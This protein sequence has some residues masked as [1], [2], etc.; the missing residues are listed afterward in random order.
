MFPLVQGLP[1]PPLGTTVWGFDV[2]IGVLSLGLF[3]GL[4]YGL[5]A[6]GLVLVYRSSR[7]INFA[8]GAL[9]VFGAAICSLAVREFEMPYW[10]AFALGLLVAAGMGALVEVGIVKPL[11]GSPRVLSMVATLGTGTALIFAALA[12]NPNGL[13]GLNFPQPTGLP[14]M[15]IG[16]LRVT[17]PFAAQALLSPLLLVA[18]GFF[19][20]KS[21]TGLAVRAA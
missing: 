19:F 4:T 7:F 12:I 9:G 6:A 15:D 21:R 18:L 13:S 20:E 11:T 8:H 2:G 5:L 17:P 1:L 10:V 16:S 3:T 14:T